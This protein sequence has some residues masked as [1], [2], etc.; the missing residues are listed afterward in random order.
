MMLTPQEDALLQWAGR[1]NGATERVTR[2]SEVLLASV[3][4]VAQRKPQ[5]SALNNDGSPLQVC[6]TYGEQGRRWR[7]LGDPA[8]GVQPGETRLGLAR[9]A[10]A[11]TLQA[12]RSTELSEVCGTMLAMAV[13]AQGLEAGTLWLAG[14]LEGGAAVYANLR[15]GVAAERWADVRR[16]LRAAL[17]DPAAALAVVDRLEPVAQV[18]SIGIE[19]S[20]LRNAR[21]KLYWRLRQQATFSTMGLPPFWSAEAGR[22]A[23]AVNEGDGVPLSGLVMS[24]SYRMADGSPADVKLDFC[25]H[26]LSRTAKEWAAM[27][28]KGVMRDEAVA[29]GV[30]RGVAEVAFL[31]VG[32]SDHGG[33]RANVYLK[34]ARA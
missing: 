24:A 31:G 14:G 22:L 32:V 30:E 17:P 23:E 1:L 5:D 26:C 18:A 9:Q 27:L 34:A 11:L 13:P 29:R 28:R 6:V 16:W 4:P 21:V 2:L 20:G 8:A 3:F 15:W 10:L 25:A 7:L 19:G 33:L 12:T